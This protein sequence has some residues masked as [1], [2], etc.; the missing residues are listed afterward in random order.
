MDFLNKILKGNCKDV[1]KTLPDKIF[2]C[3]VT[4]PPYFGL[5]DYNTGKWEGGAIDCTHFKESKGLHANTG[6]KNNVGG[7]GDAIYKNTCP[8]CGAKRID[9]QIG[10][11]ETPERYI[12]SL[13]DV[14]EE[15]KRTLTDDGTL[16]INIGDSYA[17][18]GA[19][20]HTSETKNLGA[21]TNDYGAVKTGGRI[22]EGIKP[23]DLIGI[24]WML[25]FALR[26]AGWYL[27]QDIIWHKENPMPESVTDRCTK[28]HEYI[29]LLSKSKHYYYDYEAIKTEMKDV[30]IKRMQRGI[31]DNHKHINGADGQTPHSMMQP[32]P[33]AKMYKNL[34]DKGLENHSFHKSRAEGKEWESESGKANKKSVWTVNTKPYPE[35][36]FATYPPE[37]ILDCI[38]AGSAEGDIILDPFSGSGTTAMVAA[39]LNRN[40]VGVELNQKYIDISNKRLD[41]ELGLFRK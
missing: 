37:L 34:Q 16:W 31:S 22:Y 13:V 38:K 14:F 8:K 29:F 27:R 40:F 33:N 10:L 30:S 32:R 18:G 35:A 12:A 6:Q 4:S 28:S 1:L 25:A 5:R 15:T 36:H 26:N 11:E 39:K 20:G 19:S 21:K 17:G 41:K 7:S 24:P 2:R 23:K 3:C 9:E